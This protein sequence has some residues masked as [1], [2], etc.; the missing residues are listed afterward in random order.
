MLSRTFPASSERAFARLRD[1]PEVSVLIVGGGVNGVGLLRE[2]ALQ[3]VDALLVEKSDFCSATSAAGT[4]VIHGGLR[5]LENAEFRL[6][7]E[8]L[9]ERNLLLKNAPHCVKPLATT[10]PLFDWTSGILPAIRNLMGFATKPGS[11]GALLVRTGLA[12]YDYLAGRESPLPRHRFRRRAAALSVRPA[13]NPRIIGT[14]TYYDAQVVCPERLCLELVLD[15]EGI[16]PEARALNYVRVRGAA[17]PAV[18][19]RDEISGETCEVR[20]RLVANASG[21]WIDCI[22]REMH[23]ESGFIGGT[24][25]SHVVLDHP[26]L[27]AATN[28]EMIYFVNLDG[29]ICIFYPFGDKIIAGATD[30]PT[31]APEEICTEE[32]V[33]YIL[34]SMRL[35][36][37]GIHVDRSHVVFRFCGV[38]PLPRSHALTPGQVS[39]DHSYPVL[40]PSHGIDFPIYS[41][42]GGKWTTFRAFA[43][44]VTGEILRQLDRRRVRQSEDLGIGGG[45]GYPA[46]GGAREG[47]LSRLEQ[48]TGIA[49]ERLAAL[50]DR[51]GTRAEEIA[52][53]LAA[54]PDRTLKNHPGYSRREIEFIVLK[55]RVAHLDDVVLRRT[56]IGLL[57]ESTRCLLWE[58]AGI[59]ASALGWPPEEAA[60]EVERTAHILETVHGVTPEL[61]DR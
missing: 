59:A 31:G 12:W 28:G 10:I 25:G 32:E 27:F 18:T 54:G 51:Y 20:P 44:Q 9:R 29:R 45:K 49:A 11:R 16:S 17:G 4:R 61:L 33:D 37:P 36:F 22:N 42:V 60:R 46:P 21:P 50:F 55:E 48:R 5:Y 35:A 57:G 34:D 19:L 30:I 3:G 24:K 14:A 43:E 56:L 39:R 53:Y 52:D 7:R 41:L 58:L 15:A 47:W 23:R 38:R 40:P 26:E 1:R 13:L 2:L 8:A 6:V